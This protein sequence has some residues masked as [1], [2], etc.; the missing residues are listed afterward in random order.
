MADNGNFSAHEATYTGF[1]K[2][3]HVSM[4]LV[5]VVTAVVVLLIAG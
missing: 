1:N 3:L 5:A 4:V 2:L